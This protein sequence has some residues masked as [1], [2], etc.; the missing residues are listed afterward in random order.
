[1]DPRKKIIFGFIL[2]VVGLAITIGTKDAAEANGGGTYVIAYGP[3]IFGALHVIRG[4]FALAA[5]KPKAAA[6]PTPPPAAPPPA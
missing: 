3:M 1:M 2:F 5:E 4:V 6:A